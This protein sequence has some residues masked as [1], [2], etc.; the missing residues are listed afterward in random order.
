MSKTISEVN[1]KSSRFEGTPDQVAVHIFQEVICPST[2]ALYKVNPQAAALFAYHIFG[3]AISHFAE[4]QS[5]ERL[6]KVVNEI[7]QKLL[8]Q[9][10]AER[11]ELKH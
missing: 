9:L 3:L 8:K 7:L 2:E 5:T 10:K 1:V 6:E 11:N 4:L